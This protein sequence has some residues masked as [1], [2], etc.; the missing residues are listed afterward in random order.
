MNSSGGERAALS[1]LKEYLA[2]V[3]L[4]PDGATPTPE[5]TPAPRSAFSKIEAESFND[6]F[7]VQTEECKEGGEDVGYIENGDYVV[8]KNIDFGNGA[9]G[10]DARIASAASGGNI[11]IRLDG[12]SGTL[13]GTCPVPSTGDW[14]T[15]E[16]V[17]CS[18]SK[19]TGKHD[20]YL[21]FTGGESYLFNVNWFKFNSGTP[22]TSSN[23][24]LTTKGDLNNDGVINLADAILLADAFNA[25]RGDS[26]YVASYDLNDDGAI[27]MSDVI[28]IAG[29]F[30]KT[31]TVST[32]TPTSTKTSTP[33]P[34]NASPSS[35]KPSYRKIGNPYLPGWE[36]I[37]DGEPVYLV[38]GFVYAHMICNST[39]SAIQN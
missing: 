22:T 39:N 25:V 34:S 13:I 37:P 5:P 8:Y 28:I 4:P 23:P 6:Q 19:V 14:Q 16:T 33:T 10:F 27:N 12:V 11:E 21:K 3:N 30:G 1:W 36:Y 31:V 38:T 29:N 18:V 9:T 35:D 17:S 24:D 32:I 15:Y 2:N 26:K 20:V 7:G